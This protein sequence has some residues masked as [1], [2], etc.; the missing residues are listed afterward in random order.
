MG[1]TR[2]ATDEVLL[3]L[4]REGRHDAEIGVR[5]GI[6]TGAV[7][8][9]KT[10]LRRRLG[11][12]AYLRALQTRTGSG[13]PWLLRRR[14]LLPAGI[15]LALFGGLLLVANLVVDGSEEI[16]AV[17]VAPSPTARPAARAPAAVTF[18]TERYED[19]GPF[20]SLARS[21]ELPF[22]GGVENRAGMSIVHLHGNAFVSPSDFAHWTPLAG[23]RGQLRI[24]A[25]DFGGRP[26][27]IQLNSGNSSTR[28]RGIATNVGPVA[29]VSSQF[30][31][32]PPVVLIRAFDDAGRQLRTHLTV[33]G[34]LH[35][36]REPLPTNQVIDRA[37]GSLV[38]TEGATAFGRIVLLAGVGASTYCDAPGEAFRCGVSWSRAQGLEMRFEGTF[39]CT[40]ATGLRYE[41]NGIR[42]DITQGFTLTRIGGFEC[43]PEVVP[44][45]QRIIPD[46]DWEILAYTAEGEPLS[47]GVLGDGTLL[48]GEFRG[49]RECPC[50]TQP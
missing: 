11:D 5:L 43:R 39:S 50:L 28:I 18:G 44:A 13:R 41:A 47:V 25:E 27:S 37:T 49:E 33:D 48:V 29:E 30:E 19:A 46:G 45:L 6:T 26:V 1:D 9:R 38:A 4:I 31:T 16:A 7:R 42:L 34:R 40:S 2:R 21:T 36:S 8:E 15:I 10:E 35:I 23:G 12:E 14:V 20:L 24:R 17:R 22:V 3:Q 32:I